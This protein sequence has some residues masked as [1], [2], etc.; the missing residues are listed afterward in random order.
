MKPKNNYSMSMAAVMLVFLMT[1][2]GLK[3][4]AQSITPC[5]TAVNVANFGLDGDM[6]ANTPGS[7]V[8]TNDDCFRNWKKPHVRATHGS[9]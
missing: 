8:G 7:L 2:I 3:A 9:A 6:T 4:N 1:A 5:S